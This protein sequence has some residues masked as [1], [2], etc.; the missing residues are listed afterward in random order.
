MN[1][2]LLGTGEMLSTW[3]RGADGKKRAQLDLGRR[4]HLNQKLCW[5]PGH[6][7][8]FEVVIDRLVWVSSNSSSSIRP[9]KLASH[10]FHLIKLEEFLILFSKNTECLIG[11]FLKFRWTKIKVKST[12]LL[13]SKNNHYLCFCE[14]LSRML[15]KYFAGIHACMCVC[16]TDLIYK[17]RSYCAFQVASYHF[18]NAANMLQMLINM[19][20]PH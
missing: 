18:T 2:F 4:M 10:L 16:D 15:S 20:L 1:D 7:G 8:N 5:G 14:S 13:Y 6:H 9:V 12:T 11:A 3:A 17:L 19:L